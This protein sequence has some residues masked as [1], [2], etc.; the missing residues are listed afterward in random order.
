METEEIRWLIVKTLLNEFPSLRR[1]VEK[2]L[3]K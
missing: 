1:K 3:Q 2:Y